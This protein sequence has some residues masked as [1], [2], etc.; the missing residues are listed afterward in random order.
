MVQYH[1]ICLSERIINSLIEAMETLAEQ[2][3][4]IYDIEDYISMRDIL[5]NELDESWKRL[6]E[7]WQKELSEKNI[8]KD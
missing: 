4:N 2:S 1:D 6:N 8:K 5:Q 3:D 7:A